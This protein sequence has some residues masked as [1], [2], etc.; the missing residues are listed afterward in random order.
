[1]AAQSSGNAARL[2]A[3]RL[4]AELLFL[5]GGAGFVT[6]ALVWSGPRANG[7][8]LPEAYAYVGIGAAIG[9]PVCLALGWVLSRRSAQ[10][11]IPAK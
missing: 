8:E 9:A 11:S 1:M 10:D 7:Y 4:L 6:G 5:V 2:G 3:A